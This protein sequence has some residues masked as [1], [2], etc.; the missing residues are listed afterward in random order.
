MSDLA[1]RLRAL[2]RCEHDDLS[3]GDEAAA[4]I[5]RLRVLLALARNN[6]IDGL[7]AREIDE[8]LSA[9]AQP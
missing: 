1:G 5:E 2:S 8:A 7:L 6:G 3:I 4:E 9:E